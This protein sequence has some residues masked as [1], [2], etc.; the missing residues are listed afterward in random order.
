[1]HSL[2]G[3]FA[4]PPP[5]YRIIDYI[6]CG[7]PGR[8]SSLSL[9]MTSTPASGFKTQILRPRLP[10]SEVAWSIGAPRLRLPGDV[11][12]NRTRQVPV[13]RNR[14]CFW[15]FS[16]AEAPS[17]TPGGPGYQTGR[18]DGLILTSASDLFQPY[19]EPFPSSFSSPKGLVLQILT[20]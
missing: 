19:N 10:P 16:S 15:R 11:R 20:P 13:R 3:S 18:G 17:R 8:G 14:A 4:N 2:I 12:E 5:I 9:S 1:M 6:A 7:I